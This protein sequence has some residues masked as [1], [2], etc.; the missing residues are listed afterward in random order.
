MLE[1]AFRDNNCSSFVFFNVD[2][3]LIASFSDCFL[4]DVP[5]VYMYL[6]PLLR[7]ASFSIFYYSHKYVAM[8][9]IIYIPFRYHHLSVWCFRID[10]LNCS[11]SHYFVI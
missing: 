5:S 6:L 1:P 8:V 11:D 9:T 2:Q 10:S 4:G 3:Q 7:F